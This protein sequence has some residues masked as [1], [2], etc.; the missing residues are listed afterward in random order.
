LNTGRTSS[1][2]LALYQLVDPLNDT[3]LRA[4][5]ARPE[6]FHCASC[7]QEIVETV[8][9]KYFKLHARWGTDRA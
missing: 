1:A 2:V 9:T 8:Q 3:S 6:A 7:G 5:F 4:L